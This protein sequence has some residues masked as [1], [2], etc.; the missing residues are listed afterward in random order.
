M[1]A[2]NEYRAYLE[3]DRAWS[4]ELQRL[5]GK[6]AGDVRYTDQGHTGPTLAPLYAE[7]RR[8]GEAWHTAIEA[9]RDEAAYWA[10]YRRET[11]R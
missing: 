7:Y 2:E 11:A 1:I 8:T 3:A 9:A 6:N 10:E 5:F 4:A